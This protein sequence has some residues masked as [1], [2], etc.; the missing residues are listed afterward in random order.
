MA[1]HLHLDGFHNVLVGDGM[2]AEQ[3][4][5]K[6]IGSLLDLAH[7]SRCDKYNGAIYSAEPMFQASAPKFVVHVDTR[8]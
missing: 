1:F 6:N 7:G 4:V 3:V 8:F 5:L 2:L